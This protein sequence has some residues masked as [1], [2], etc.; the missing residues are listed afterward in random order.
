MSPVTVR[1]FKHRPGSW[2]LVIHHDGKRHT[3]KAGETKEE[4]LKLK[5]D[6]DRLILERGYS[7]LDAFV[8]RGKAHG[9][10]VA[11]YAEKW[12]EEIGE[13]GLR[14]ASIASYESNIRQ[15]I[16]PYFD[17]LPLIDITYSRVKEFVT[18]KSKATYTRS[19][20]EGARQYSYSKDAIRLM[21]ATFRAM[22]EEA[23]REEIIKVNPVHGLGRLFS[24]AKKLR[25][26]PLPF[27]LEEL[28][29][30][31]EIA[32]E[33]LPFLMFQ[34][35]TGVRVGEAIA[36]QWCDLDLRNGRAHIRRNMPINRQVG[37]PKSESSKR[38]VDLSPEL[39]GV[40]RD[41]NRQQREYW[42]GKGQ[43]PPEWVFAKHSRQAPDYSV[44]RQ[45]F[46]RL[47]VKAQV[48]RRRP[49]DLR[50]TYACL[51]L[52]VGKPITYV[53]SQMGHKNPQITLSIYSRWVPGHDSGDKGI[54]DKTRQQHVNRRQREGKS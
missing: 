17:N 35:R 19:R 16:Q 18:D 44:W 27:S 28:H 34:A 22:L 9:W 11:T 40:L 32:G 49:H 36:L 24:S 7:A 25:E 5:R 54:M 31:E 51:N 21:I 13:S 6:V 26:D 50:H 41:L 15:H 2:Y 45:A 38:T 14:K 12:L 39:V 20:K 46:N 23:V 1:E 43:E 29:R 8:P 4:A 37:P 52:A 47:Q 42:F 3:F 33:W 48:P 10:T 30:V 53:S